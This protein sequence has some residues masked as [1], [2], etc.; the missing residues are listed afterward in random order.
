MSASRPALV[1][2]RNDHAVFRNRECILAR[3]ICRC[4]T[5]IFAENG[6]IAATKGSCSSSRISISG[7]ESPPEI[8][9]ITVHS[10]AFANRL[11]LIKVGVAWPVSVFDT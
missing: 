11:K 9:S 7:T 10:S 8:R 1:E 2:R 5:V 6:A 4:V 3:T